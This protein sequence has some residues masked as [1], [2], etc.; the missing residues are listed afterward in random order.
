MVEQRPTAE[1]TARPPESVPPNPTSPPAAPDSGPAAPAASAKP[2]APTEHERPAA[3]PEE[4]ISSGTPGL[5]DLLGGG[6]PRGHVL[7]IMGSFGTGKT[8]LA[9]QFLAEGIRKGERVVFVTLE[10]EADHV[11]L[12]ADRYGHDFR[13]PLASGQLTILKLSPTDARATLRKVNSDL[14]K[15]LRET[16]ATRIVLDSATLLSSVFDTDIDRRAVLFEL[17]NAV[18]A[19]GSTAL[20]TAELSSEGDKLTSRDGLVEYVADG[21]VAL[22][23]ASGD[24]PDTSLDL[25]MVVVKLRRSAH[26]RRIARY[27][28]TDHGIELRPTA[29]G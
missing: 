2:S 10:E 22:R 11:I 26:S 21:V 13:A 25:E 14:L 18:R 4:R 23:Y 27:D 15:F 5:D 28:I 29:F 9:I 12:T 1:P 6:I 3:H 7:C 17:A 19:G 20:F 8:T 24:K 16:H